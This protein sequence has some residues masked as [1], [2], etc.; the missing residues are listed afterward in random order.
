MEDK[1]LINDR[2]YGK[3]EIQEPVIVELI[4]T[5]SIQR[6]KDIHQ[7]GMPQRFYPF[8]GYSRYE[9]SLGVMLTLKE[10][11]ADLEEQVAG[12]L[13]DVSHTAFSHTVD[14]VVGSREKEDFQDKNLKTIITNSDI[15]GILMRHGIDTN[16]ITEHDNYPLLERPAPYLCADRVDYTL[17][18]SKT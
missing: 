16:R 2:V 13:H 15:P 17:R 6:L 10:L 9:H 1:V 5:D 18:E 3:Y 7:F 8:P 14:W 4:N 11:G 12:L